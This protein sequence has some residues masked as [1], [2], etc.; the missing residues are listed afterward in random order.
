LWR[1]SLQHVRRL[2]P[3][4][5][6]DTVLTFKDLALVPASYCFSGDDVMANPLM[7]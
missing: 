5:S 7:T 3:Q 2:P 1:A 6:V 4:L